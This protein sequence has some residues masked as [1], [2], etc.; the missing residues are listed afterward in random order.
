MLEE[1]NQGFGAGGGG[2]GGGGVGGDLGQEA[3]MQPA[4]SS[5]HLPLLHIALPKE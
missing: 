2:G 3:E 1:G 4:S 5:L